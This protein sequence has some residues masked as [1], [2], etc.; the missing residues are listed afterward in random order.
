MTN[1]ALFNESFN[2]QF[3]GVAVTVEKY[4]KIFNQKHGQ[5]SVIVPA[6]PDRKDIFPYPVWE[7]PS[8]PITVGD[9]YRIGLPSPA[10]MIRKFNASN[11]E[12]I[13][14]HCPFTS[15]LLA[16]RL[17]TRFDLPH[18]STFHSKFKD[19]VNM[20]LKT[21]LKMPGEIVAKYVSAFYNRCDY[22]WAVSEGT[23]Q[24]LRSYGYKGEIT[25]MP[26]GC[27]MPITHRDD[28]KRQ[29]LMK[30]NDMIDAPILLF[31]G[32][33]TFTK[34]TD[35]IIKALGA[36]NRHGIKFNMLFVGDG[37]DKAKMEK[38]VD[39]QG[40][41]RVVRF[42]GKISDRDQLKDIY[43]S[44]DLFVFPS[45]YD[46]APLVVRE[47]AACGC[48]SALIRG[49]NSAEGMQDGLN[50]FLSDETVEDFALTLSMAITSGKL[51][52]VGD[53]ARRDIYISWD[54]VLE[55]VT[56]EYDRVLTDW[57]KHEHKKLRHENINEILANFDILKE[58]EIQWPKPK[59]Q[60]K[61]KDSNDKI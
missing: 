47:A 5:V 59:K 25:V 26:N 23:A 34:N 14:S 1:L 55:M 41:Q 56:S 43:A 20:R 29:A 18:I 39:E 33:H 50:A 10:K 38:M 15:G 32:R 12:V 54:D 52:S 17:A 8:S 30:K 44:S 35:I 36:I 11:I 40:L 7:Y 61:S 24:T 57:D 27:D 58:Y 60:K 28:E 16:Q 49:S 37:E 22:V 13:H 6:H 51:D 4:A 9:Q 31:V 53:N 48:A 3:D 42:M 21:N 2:P 19:D 45:V 46:N